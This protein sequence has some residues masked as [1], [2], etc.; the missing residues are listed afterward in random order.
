LYPQ[1]LDSVGRPYGTRRRAPAA[2]DVATRSPID[3]LSTPDRLWVQSTHL[4]IEWLTHGSL[5]ATAARLIWVVACFYALALLSYVSR[6]AALWTC[7]M[8]IA[9]VAIL[10][11]DLLW[12]LTLF[13]IPFTQYFAFS[14]N[15]TK[16]LVSIA[17]AACGLRLVPRTLE[18]LRKRAFL[19]SAYS[20]IFLLYLLL[21]A[22][23]FRGT[24][25]F[26]ELQG[27]ALLG[28]GYLLFVRIRYAKSSR[29]AAPGLLE[30]AFVGSGIAAAILS[31]VYL[32]FPLPQLI[33]AHLPLDNLR[34]AAVTD[35][36]NSM[37]RFLLPAI[38]S[39]LSRSLLHR[40]KRGLW[41]LLLALSAM[42]VTATGSKAG[43]ASTLAMLFLAPFLVN[44]RQ[45]QRSLWGILVAAAAM[46]SWTFIIGPRVEYYA[47]SKHTHTTGADVSRYLVLRP[48]ELSVH[49]ILA[50][51]FR[52]GTSSEMLKDKE[53]RTLYITRPYNIWHTGQRDRLWEAGIAVLGDHPLWGIG[54]K[55][56]REELLRR[57]DYP[58]VAPHNALLEVA[59][60]YGIMG[61]IL[62]VGL[63]VVFLRRTVQVRRLDTVDWLRHGATWPTLACGALF[64]FEMFDE[65]TSLGVTLMILWVWGML[66]IQ[67]A[68]VT[69]AFSS[70]R[71]QRRY[72]LPNLKEIGPR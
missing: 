2:Q 55:A 45:R 27:A 37:A 66:A 43:L 31:L 54:Y 18:L 11:A 4:Y 14:A 13:L 30:S 52:I 7:G 70:G 48:E 21:V 16:F 68:I 62:Y 9:I 69:D 64:V 39:F 1:K 42:L 24:R 72:S 8:D 38:A 19:H 49:D 32:Y 33:V 10:S 53:G 60:S 15:D 61:G 22:L 51:D 25:P 59:G 57:I 5:S 47:A 23:H 17:L 44:A 20:W 41:Y 6:P 65:A 26:F 40:S 56:W 67:E 35:G 3:C 58:F 63:F 50:R 46:L 34:L 29:H 71:E 28:I 12:L 36:P